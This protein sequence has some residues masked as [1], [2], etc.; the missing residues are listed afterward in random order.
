MTD[1]FVTTPT[2]AI[3]LQAVFGLTA[4]VLL[5]FAHFGLLWWNVGFFA[6]GG[7]WKA[8]ALQLLR[9]AALAIV[10]YSVA[11]FG[12]LAL[13]CAALGI[14]IARGI[15]LRRGRGLS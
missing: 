11:Q 1:T 15:L 3:L 6:D 4:G 5:G 13:L 10:L 14:L 9:F 2:S 7:L 8:L 12:A